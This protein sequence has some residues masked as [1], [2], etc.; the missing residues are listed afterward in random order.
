MA[1]DILKAGSLIKITKRTLLPKPVSLGRM[2][3]KS[4]RHKAPEML[5]GKEVRRGEM[6]DKPCLRSPL[7]LIF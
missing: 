7:G 4:M 3:A 1:Y 2:P 6:D 5:G